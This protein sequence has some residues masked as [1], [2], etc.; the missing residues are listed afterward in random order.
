MVGN[1]ITV[2]EVRITVV[3]KHLMGKAKVPDGRSLY[4]GFKVLGVGEKSG[5]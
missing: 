1:Q 3:P 4:Y 5:M 2:G